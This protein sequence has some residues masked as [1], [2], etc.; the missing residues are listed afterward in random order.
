MDKYLKQFRNWG[1]CCPREYFIS[2][3]VFGVLIIYTCLVY[4]LAYNKATKDMIEKDLQHRI[5]KE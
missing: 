1:T 2:L 3:I 4:D 5:D